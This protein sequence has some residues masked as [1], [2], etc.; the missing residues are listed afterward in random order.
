MLPQAESGLS[1]SRWEE[2]E[3]ASRE[4]AR[5]GNRA[6]GILEELANA[7]DAE[8]RGRAQALLEKLTPDVDVPVREGTD[9]HGVVIR[10]VK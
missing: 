7:K 4:L 1:S 8:V 6:R 10:A 5:W 3:E 2:R 9:E